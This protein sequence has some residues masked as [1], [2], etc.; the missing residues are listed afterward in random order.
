MTMM[1]TKTAARAW[2]NQ[3]LVRCLSLQLFQILR[4]RR[5][6]SQEVVV[7]LPSRSCAMTTTMMTS[8]MVALKRK[9]G[10]ASLSQDAVNWSEPVHRRRG[11]WQ[12]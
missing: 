10:S 1:M 4:G 3:L 12:Q 2:M 5:L 11:T 7:L 8:T 9:A 6:D